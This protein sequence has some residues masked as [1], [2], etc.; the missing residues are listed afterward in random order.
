MSAPIQYVGSVTRSPVGD[1]C[2]V[3]VDVTF[4]QVIDARLFGQWLHTVIVQKIEAEGGKLVSI[5]AD[6]KPVLIH[7]N[8]QS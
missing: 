4:A 6:K 5:C 3:R 2:T 7:R 1:S 8:M